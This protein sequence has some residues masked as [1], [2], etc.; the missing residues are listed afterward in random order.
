[1]ARADTFEVNDHDESML[2]EHIMLEL[3]LLFADKT[4]ME[5]AGICSRLA[6]MIEQRGW[7]EAIGRF[8]NSP[9][10][11]RQGEET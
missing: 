5:R 7:D 11:V 2:R 6:F 8:D 4:P 10:Q 9:P 1:M 3:D